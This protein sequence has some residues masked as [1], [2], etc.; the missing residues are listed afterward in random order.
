MGSFYLLAPRIAGGDKNK[1]LGYFTRAI[2]VDPNFAD[3]YVR[4]AQLAKIR[5]NQA[6]YDLYMDKALKLDS[7]NELALDT[8]SGRCKFICVG[9]EE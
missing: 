8:L 6:E 2:E 9:G 4:F 7:G 1:A 5:G 3:V